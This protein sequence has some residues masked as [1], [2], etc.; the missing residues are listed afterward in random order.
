MDNA[1]ALDL[2]LNLKASRALFK[3]DSPIP[4]TIHLERVDY[5][6]LDIVNLLEASARESLELEDEELEDEQEL[7]LEL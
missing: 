3:T 5:F 4:G 7:E 6:A 2:K 1:D